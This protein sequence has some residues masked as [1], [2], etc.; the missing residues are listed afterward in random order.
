MN[1]EL[2]EVTIHS[3]SLLLF[4]YLYIKLELNTFGADYEYA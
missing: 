3:D 2:K 1:I 4:Y